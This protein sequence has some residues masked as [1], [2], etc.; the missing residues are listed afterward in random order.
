MSWIYVDPSPLLGSDVPPIG[1]P[2]A[3]QHVM[4]IAA[5][6]KS[7]LATNSA[8]ITPQLLQ[9]IEEYVQQ[10]LK[11]ELTA[12][13]DLDQLE[14]QESDTCNCN[15]NCEDSLAL[16]SVLSNHRQVLA[17]AARLYTHQQVS[18]ESSVLLPWEERLEAL[19]EHH[20][21]EM[22]NLLATTNLPSTDARG[23][24]IVGSAVLQSMVERH[25]AQINK[26]SDDLLN[27]IIDS[28]E[29]LRADFYSFIR[30]AAS[31][32]M[33][34]IRISSDNATPHAAPSIDSFRKN[35]PFERL[36]V[37]NPFQD[38]Q[39]G[40]QLKAKD[41]L[42]API[43]F[44]T[45]KL[46]YLA[47]CVSLYSRT[48]DSGGIEKIEEHLRR[49][50]TN[51]H[52]AL[53]CLGNESKWRKLLADHDRKSLELLRSDVHTEELTVGGRRIKLRK[54]TNMWGGTVQLHVDPSTCVSLPSRRRVEVEDD[55]A[56]QL[57][58]DNIDLYASVLVTTLQVAAAHNCDLLTFVLLEDD[59]RGGRHSYLY[60]PFFRGLVQAIAML[61]LC[62]GGSRQSTSSTVSPSL[63]LEDPR[64]TAEL[65][66]PCATA[67]GKS[68]LNFNTAMKIR[69]FL[70]DT[71][72]HVVHSV[73]GS[74]AEVVESSA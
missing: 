68:R 57:E 58:E 40:G 10:Q 39:Q 60:T 48:D 49:L 12:M 66:W 45:S 25:E 47:D 37:A 56:L 27:L 55:E 33:K 42:L 9:Q 62:L 35:I 65:F 8:N 61:Q 15:P 63:L 52:S 22:S 36:R 21:E 17:T 72:L 5:T 59:G 46:S 29:R 64:S 44:E 11:K 28:T 54:P 34:M 31:D 67:D 7:W 20:S 30:L 3:E 74:S 50:G 69:V 70:P 71:A 16:L 24:V 32:V 13:W 6:V 73:L 41:P 14:R 19:R 51:R 23:D 2:P 38:L 18:H 53:V 4:Y 1:F 43:I 26:M